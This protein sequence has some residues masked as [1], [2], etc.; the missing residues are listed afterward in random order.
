MLQ[1]NNISVDFGSRSLFENL[2]LTVKPTDKIGLAGRNGA[3]KSTL[4]KIISGIDLPTSGKI[5]VPK[6]H[7]TNINLFYEPLANTSFGH[8]FDKKTGIK[9]EAVFPYDQNHLGFEFFAP[10][11]PNPEKTFYCCCR[12]LSRCFSCRWLNAHGN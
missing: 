12:Y 10:N 9:K 6:I 1:L 3:G 2:N 8:F 5:I 11:F 7:F 4:L